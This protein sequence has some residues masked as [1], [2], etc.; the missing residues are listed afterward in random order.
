[1]TIDEVYQFFGSPINSYKSIGISRE[2]FFMWI[3]RGYI[4][5]TAQKKI[6]ILTKGALIARLEDTCPIISLETNF[7]LFRYYD[8]KNGMCRV[9]SIYFRAGK[10][11]KITYVTYTQNK[12]FTVFTTDNLMQAIDLQD[13]E[14]KILYEGDICRLKS[15][16]KYIFESIEMAYQF[17]KLDKFKIIGNI[18]E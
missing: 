16:K 15:G 8:K 9:E 18:F 5:V 17:R 2:T 7:P 6:E 1:M 13:S 3:K 12:K 11:P 10:P 4:P 14:G